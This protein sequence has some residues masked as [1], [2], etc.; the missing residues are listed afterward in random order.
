LPPPGAPIMP[1]IDFIIRLA[2]PNSLSS[3][4]TCWVVVPEPRA[5]RS[6]RLPLMTWG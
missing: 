1:I 4:F 3:E 6:R 2:C 5:M